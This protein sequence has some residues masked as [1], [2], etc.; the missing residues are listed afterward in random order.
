MKAPYVLCYHAVSASWPARLAISESLLAKQ[1]GILAGRGFTGLTLVDAERRRAAGTLPARSLVVTFDDAYESTLRAKPILDDLG[2]PAT[3]F[4]VTSFPDSG[5]P[6]SWPGVEEWA[7]GAWSAEMT[8][9]GWD[10]LEALAGA[11]WEIGSHTAT[12]P[13]LPDIS[14]DALDEELGRSRETI[15]ARLGNCSTIAYPYGLADGR[16]ARAAGNAGYAA[17]VT[18]TPVHR[19][20]E[21]LRRPRI[22]LNRRD[23]GLRLQTKLSPAFVSF[24]RTSLA[25]GAEWL[26]GRLRSR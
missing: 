3:V 17:G 10:A 11:G 18:L 7:R 22:G 24:R 8:P 19:V 6:L 25:R 1:L 14:D 23:T 13:R 20:D 15:A 12:H 26:N 4:A 16:V 5:R 21:P 9:L 2:F